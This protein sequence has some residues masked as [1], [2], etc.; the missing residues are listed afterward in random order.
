[1][2]YEYIL[3]TRYTVQEPCVLYKNMLL[4]RR[5]IGYTKNNC[6]RCVPIFEIDPSG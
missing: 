1:M 6:N 5:K 2:L 4:N 3:Y